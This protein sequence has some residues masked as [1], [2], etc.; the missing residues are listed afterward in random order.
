[1]IHLS[2]HVTANRHRAWPTQMLNGREHYVVPV[3]M[4][5]PGVLSGSRGSLYYSPQ[6]I[7]A[8]YAAWNG[9]PL[10][11]YHPIR[12]GS[13]VSAR[14]SEVL[15]AQ[16]I[17]IVR[18]S[19]IASNGKLV[20]EG[21][22][23]IER[24]RRVDRRVLHALQRGDQI[25]LSTGLF[26]DTIPVRNGS[27]HHGKPYTH[28]ATNFTPDHLAILPDQLGACSI[29]DGCGVGVENSKPKGHPLIP[30]KMVW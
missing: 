1:M 26:T 24:T 23:D 6:E 27:H 9:M 2:R 13:P 17:G 4:I 8:N 21:W 3:T 14:S 20:A 16:G 10:V 18:R 12:N 19:R 29:K 22:F 11:V 25:E 5:V 28:I 7:A 15:N 30:P